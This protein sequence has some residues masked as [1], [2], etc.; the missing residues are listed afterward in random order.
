[1][2]KGICAETAL[3]YFRP[4]LRKRVKNVKMRAMA[5]FA[6]LKEERKL[7]KK[8]CGRVFCLDEAGRGSLAGPVVACAAVILPELAGPPLSLPPAAD[9][10]KLPAAKREEIRAAL[11]GCPAVRWG[12][13]TVSA[14]VVDRLNVLEAAK[15]AMRRA[16]A[17]L[18]RKLKK[19]GL[20]RPRA[21]FLLIDGN[22]KIKAEIFQKPVPGADAKIYSCAAAS[23][24][25]KTRRDGIMEKYG[26]KHPGYG[27]ARH[28]GYPT[29]FHKKALDE[30][31]PCAIHRM[32]FR[33]VRRCA[34]RF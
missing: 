33:P 5:R 24:I 15:E 6:S 4:L 25:A 7:W 31:G 16:A 20:P 9:S 10:K 27:F 19:A 34:K 28:K 17:N 8:G 2:E 3:F 22:F 32:S 21:D 30:R 12:I 29:A 13:G 26:R 1:M 11:A 18:E 14:K 23:I